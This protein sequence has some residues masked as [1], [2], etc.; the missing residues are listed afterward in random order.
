ML[1]TIAKAGE[2]LGV[3]TKTLRRWE[4]KGL[5]NPIRTLGNH[6]RYDSDALLRFQQTKIYDPTPFQKT[7]KAAIYARVTKRRFGKTDRIPQRESS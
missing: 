5:I 1:V 4:K 6:R 7:G 2:V 3:C